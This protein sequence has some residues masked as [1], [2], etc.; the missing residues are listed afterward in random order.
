MSQSS[1]QPT[2]STPMQ[3]DFVVVQYEGQMSLSCS[4]EKAL[5]STDTHTTLAMVSLVAPVHMPVARLPLEIVAVVDRSGSMSGPKMANMKQTLQF[6]VNKGMQSGD[7]LAI[8]A[9]DDTV[10]TR[11]SLTI[12]DGSGKS[13]ALDAIK[14]IH[15]GR[16]TNLS[17][18]LLQGIDLLQRA[19]APSGGSTRAVLL[20]TDGIANNGI[21]DNAGILEAARGAMTDT[22]MPLFMFG[23]GADHNE[24]MLRSLAGATNGLYYYLEKEETIPEAFADCLGGLVAVVAQNA[25]LVLTPMPGVTISHVH[26]SYKQTQG[27]NSAIEL[28][29]GDVYAEEEKDIVLQLSLPALP[30]PADNGAP[31]LV[32]TLRIPW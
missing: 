2:S 32:A 12:M 18:G 26:A 21:T 4:A 16:T 3:E 23:F 14:K 25:T 1:E 10:D 30:A 7:S 9:F 27:G 6:L 13:E 24:D 28:S 11:L 29:L 19:P 15:P 17:G 20:F 8:V 31:A 22:A 5:S